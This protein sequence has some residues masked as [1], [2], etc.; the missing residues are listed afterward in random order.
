MTARLFHHGRL[1][2]GHTYLGDAALATADGRIVAVGDAATVREACPTGAQ[3]VDLQGGL[4]LPGFHDAH[5]H[6]MVGGLERR[7]CDLSG[8]STP[9]EYLDALRSHADRQQD[10]EWVRGGGWSISAFPLDG[11]TAAQLDEVV[12]DRPAFIVSSDHH[13]AWVNSRALEVAGISAAT[14]DPSDGWFVRDEHGNPTGPLREAAMTP[15]WELLSTTREEYAAS[16]AD[17]QA[18]LHSC[19]IT[20]WHDALVGGYAGLDDPTQAYLDLAAEGRLTGRVRASLWWDRHRGPEQLDELRER[21]DRLAEAG[22]DAG[23][24]KIMMDGISETFT[25]AMTEPY[26]DLHDCPCGDRGMAF[27]E[28]DQAAEAVT[29]IDAAGFA[30]HVHAIGDWAVHQALNAFEAARRAN[31]MNDLPHQIAHLQLVR[32]ADRPRF[33]HLAVTANLEGMWAR[34]R[35]PAVE[36]LLPH[37]GEDRLRWHYPFAEIAGYGAGLAGGSDWPVNPATPMSGVHTLVNRQA[38][39]PDGD[40]AEP[41][42]PEQALTL[43]QALTA[44]TSGAARVNNRPDLGVLQVGAGADLVVLDR[45]PFDG[46]ATAG[47]AQ[48]LT[49]YLDGEPVH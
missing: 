48:V 43:S 2:D 29:A 35:T 45:D 14:P 44:Y 10:S 36:M 19:G 24:V 7:T 21:R 12:P 37:L 40:P 16:L 39:D 31:G 49:T 27:L 13:D 1:F 22:V 38:Y 23:S 4:L 11:P 9:E 33:R 25:A 34:L 41:L 30:V 20:G 8:M 5:L 3:E 6:P 28:P 18:Y 47:A 15:V 42:V 46:P 32:P 17:G 26:V